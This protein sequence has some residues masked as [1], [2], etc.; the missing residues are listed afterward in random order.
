M[1][2]K[3]PMLHLKFILINFFCS[4]AGVKYPVLFVRGHEPLLLGCIS[5]NLN[6]PGLSDL[7]L[8]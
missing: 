6:K 2:A 4:V 7:S 5:A 1:A 3:K 8:I